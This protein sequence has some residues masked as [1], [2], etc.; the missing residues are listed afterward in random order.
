MKHK[1]FLVPILDKWLLF[2]PLHK[3]AAV[4]NAAA[5]KELHSG[6]IDSEALKPIRQELEYQTVATPIPREGEICPSFLGIIPTRGCNIGCVYCN[7]GGPTQPRDQ[8]KPEIAVAAVDWMA[9]R[10][11]RAGRK[12]FQ[13]HFFGGEPFV[14]PDVIDIVVHRARYQA[15]QR[16]L[17][18]YIDA[19]TNGV[20]SD[21]RRQFVG[22][23]FGSV[24]LSFD[25]PPEFHNRNRPGKN[26]KPTFEAVSR[27]ARWLSEMP[28][29]LCIRVCV[30]QDSVHQLEEITRW[31][32]DTYQ[33]AIVNFESLT[34]GLLAQNAG[35]KVPDP[36]DFAIHTLRVYRLAEQLGIKVVYSAGEIGGPRLSF[37]PVG[38]DALIVSPDGRA[39]ACYLLPE[40]WRSRGLDMD[41]GWVHADGSFD[42]DFEALTRSRR[43]P[44]DKPR[45][46]KCFCQWTCA[47]GCHVNQTYP[48]STKDYT[49]FCIQ[50]RLL[51]AF[52]L[53]HDLDFTDLLN[54]LMADREALESLGEY[55][56]DPIEIAGAD[57]GL[58]TEDFQQEP[59]RYKSL[60]GSGLN[61][62]F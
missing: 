50:T 28:I 6:N 39:S 5:A 15:A 27:T 47:G 3:F 42:I 4:V 60:V 26:G 34:P 13:I 14:S 33:P 18:T 59:N 48:E 44:A 11:E 1:L 46:E 41:L 52:R 31:L 23:Y 45:C 54:E 19:S 43:L 25:G 29:D 20:F 32:I 17:T 58:V 8:M 55:A 12:L 35:L 30:T 36:Y 61:I 62:I 2:A 21:S 24:V 16:G 49:E 56:W 51:T 22:D 38:T 53:L 10:L 7:F 37:C 57:S 40:D 9:E